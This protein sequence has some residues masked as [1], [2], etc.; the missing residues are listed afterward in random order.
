MRGGDVTVQG[1]WAVEQWE[2]GQDFVD[3]GK[4]CGRA[5]QTHYIMA[6]LAKNLNVY[7]VHRSA[8]TNQLNYTKQS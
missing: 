4:G 1:G 7:K 6:T 3:S 5:R 8:N 2:V